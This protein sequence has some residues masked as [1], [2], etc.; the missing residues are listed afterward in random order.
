LLTLHVIDDAAL[1]PQTQ[2][3]RVLLAGLDIHEVDYRPLRQPVASRGCATALELTL[4][5][6]GTFSFHCRSA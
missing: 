2:R 6:H 3:A 1:Q 5:V 4:T